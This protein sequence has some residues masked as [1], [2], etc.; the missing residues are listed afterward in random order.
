MSNSSSAAFDPR[1]TALRQQFQAKQKR[2]FIVAGITELTVLVGLV[3]ALFVFEVV[4]EPLRPIILLATLVV[5][6][7][8]FGMQ[9]VAMQRA[10]QRDLRDITGRLT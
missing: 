7:T 2:F 9:L 3:V 5:F 10:Y 8:A 4:D 1:V 6:S